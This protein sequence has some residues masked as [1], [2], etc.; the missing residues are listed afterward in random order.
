MRCIGALGMVPLLFAIADG[1]PRRLR[2]SVNSSPNVSAEKQQ[3]EFGLDFYLDILDEEFGETTFRRFLSG[4]YDY[5]PDAE[6]PVDPD[7]EDLLAD[8]DTE[9]LVDSSGH[10]VAERRNMFMDQ[11]STLSSPDLIDQ[12]GSPQNLALQWIV[13][14]DGLQI[15]PDDPTLT[16]RYVMAV[17]YYST[18]G[19]DWINCN[20]ENSANPSPCIAID[21]TNSINNQDFSPCYPNATEPWLSSASECEWCGNSCNNNGRF[22]YRNVSNGTITD[23]GLENV[24]QSGT[25]PIELN[26]LTDLGMLLL[27]KG[28]IGGSIPSEIGSIENLIVL[29]L[30]F[31]RL[32]GS[33]PEE[34]FNLSL[35]LQLDLNNNLF[36]G[37][38]SS[39]IMNLENLAFLQRGVSCPDTGIKRANNNMFTF[40]ILFSIILCSPAR[41]GLGNNLF[42]GTLPQFSL[43]TKDLNVRGN[44]LIGNLE[45][46]SEYSS[47]RT[48]DVSDNKLEGTIPTSAAQPDLRAVDFDGNS[49]MGSMPVEMCNLRDNATIPGNLQLLKATCSGN[50]DL[51]CDCCTEC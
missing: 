19:D 32:S 47:L 2:A 16:Q 4:S 50:E 42:I 20:D 11:L 17:F 25:L 38:L 45:S 5:D 7:T 33:I 23:I 21:G 29:D 10:T 30:D 1:Q 14:N 15:S 44:Q 18:N 6:V 36:T 13:E 40:D 48:L 26:A 46:I 12:E 39:S 35:L 24:N 8:L 37:T 51:I 49:L 22:P 31:Q 34:I 9:D 27:E 28:S 3:Q 43:A 41:L